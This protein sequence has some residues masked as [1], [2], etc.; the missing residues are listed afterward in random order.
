MYVIE[1]IGQFHES[2]S[3][4]NTAVL[5][6]SGLAGVQDSAARLDHFIDHFRYV[7]RVSLVLPGLHGEVGV[8]QNVDVSY[9][10]ETGD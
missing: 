2:G 4:H 8:A 6:F 10:E 3:L 1:E 9:A 7:D 5:P